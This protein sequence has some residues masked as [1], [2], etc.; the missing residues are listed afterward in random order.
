MS[1]QAKSTGQRT[2]PPSDMKH[3]DTLVRSLMLLA[4]GC[5]LWWLLSPSPYRSIYSNPRGVAG[6]NGHVRVIWNRQT[7]VVSVD[8]RTETVPQS[9]VKNS[10]IYQEAM[11]RLPPDIRPARAE[12]RWFSPSRYWIPLCALAWW[13]LFRVWKPRQEPLMIRDSNEMSGAA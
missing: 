11:L 10:P 5:L 3:H 9:D 4:V 6:P 2:L 13:F 12:P 8:E 1:I 7:V